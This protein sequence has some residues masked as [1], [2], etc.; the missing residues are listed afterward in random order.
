[1]APDISIVIPVYNGAAYLA[2]CLKAV[3]ELRPAPLECIVVDDGSTDGSAR[4]AQSA[5]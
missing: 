2:A 3:R 5:A 1:M 4:I